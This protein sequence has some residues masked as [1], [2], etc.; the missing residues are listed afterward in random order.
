MR[1]P[2]SLP[3]GI[4]DQK[5]IKLF[6]DIIRSLT[7]VLDLNTYKLTVVWNPP[8]TLSIPTFGNMSRSSSPDIVRCAR[9]VDTSSRTTPV[10]FGA[11]FWSWVGDGSV[12]IDD[13]DGLVAGVKYELTFEV[14]G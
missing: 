11:T 9:A 6:T 14:V 5:T 1:F 2:P 3:V 10:H 7:G 13:V 12:R 8:I 4:G